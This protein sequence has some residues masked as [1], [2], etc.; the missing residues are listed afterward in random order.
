[1]GAKEQC[2][3]CPKALSSCDAGLGASPCHRQS[4]VIPLGFA[5]GE[6][7]NRTMSNCLVIR[8]HWVLFPAGTNGSQSEIIDLNHQ[9]S[10]V[11]L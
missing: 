3:L 8:N 5:L 10:L 6:I 2:F 4:L 7:F 11:N 1:M 9:K